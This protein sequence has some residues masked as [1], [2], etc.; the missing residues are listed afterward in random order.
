MNQRIFGARGKLLQSFTLLTRVRVEKKVTLLICFSMN[1]LKYT[2]LQYYLVWSAS[3]SRVFFISLCSKFSKKKTQNDSSFLT[4]NHMLLFCVKW[5]AKNKS[6]EL[7]NQIFVMV[8]RRRLK[9]V[10]LMGQSP[11]SKGSVFKSNSPRI[12]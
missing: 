5:I 11:F 10:P 7:K 9:R 3:F 2:Q 12:G 8:A 6:F 1:L 4:T